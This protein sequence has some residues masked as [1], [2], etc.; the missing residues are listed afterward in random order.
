MSNKGNF[1]E[2]ERFSGSGD[3]QNGGRYQ[4]AVG[5]REGVRESREEI[6]NDIGVRIEGRAVH[7]QG[8]LNAVRTI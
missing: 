5:G 1:D 2:N 7:G 8:Y 6:R 3:G 4:I